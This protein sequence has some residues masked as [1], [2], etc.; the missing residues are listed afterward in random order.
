MGNSEPNNKLIK[1]ISKFKLA[2]VCPM[3]NE[4]DTAIQFVERMLEESSIFDEVIFIA[5][6]DTVSSDGTLDILKH[7]ETKERRLRV[8]W[9][10]ENRCAVDAYLRGYEEA[11]STNYDWILEVDAGFSHQP[12]DL[13]NFYSLMN[14]DYDC[15][16]GSRFCKGGQFTECSWWH[17][18]ISR[19]GTVL[20]NALLGTKLTDMTSGYQLFRRQALEKILREGIFSRG[21]FFQTEMKT[22]CHS[23]RIAE[24]PIHY[25]SG[26]NRIHSL[27]L[28]DA[29]YN[30][31]RLLLKRLNGSPHV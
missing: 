2:I 17:Y 20:T 6:L 10:P 16:F 28:G 27:M 12:E 11:V 31:S 22:L 29:F 1:E 15:I 24:V 13:P 9:A 8:I 26:S 23:M 5:I 14:E 3:A 25:R 18:L 21:R 4:R 7:L 30:L 19:G